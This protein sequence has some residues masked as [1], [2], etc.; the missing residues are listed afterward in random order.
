MAAVGAIPPVPPD[1]A[2]GSAARAERALWIFVGLTVFAALGAT[3]RGMQPTY[4]LVLAVVPLVLVA[5]QRTLLSWHTLLASILVVILFIP[6]RRYTVAGGAP[7]ELEPYRI[8]IALVLGSWFLALA[9]DPNVRWR[10][11]GYGAP[12][13]LLWVGI[14]GGLVA[15][16]GRVNNNS[17]QVLKSIT[18]F[19]SY[20]LV[21]CFVVSTIRKGRELDRIMKLLVGGGAIV[22]CCALY[23]WRT[24]VNLFN[25]LGRVLPFLVYQD[26]GEAMI[27]GTGARAL[28][29]AQHPIALGAG[30]VMLMPMA[31][32]LFNRTR[33]LIWLACGVLLVLGAL[34]TGSRTAA[35]MLAVVFATFAWQKRQEMM[36]LLP[37]WLVMLVVIQGVMPG[38]LQSFKF[39]L[40]PA[41]AIQEQS[42]SEGTG[43]GRVADLGP[44]LS[45][46]AHGN[47][48]V[49]EGF[50]TRVTTQDGVE[51]GAQILDDQ[52][53]TT[54]LEAGAAG[55]IALM[56]LFLRAIRRLSRRARETTGA[57]S[58]L[59][60]SLASALI[61]WTIGLFTFDAFAFIQVTFFAFI[62]LGFAS[63]ALRN[64]DD[65]DAF[66]AR[67]SG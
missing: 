36:R 26:I 6:I 32:Y 55:V 5:F 12:I 63:V 4:V 19:A 29:S 22:A 40:N 41:Y 58:W 14:L 3:E 25:G 9:A 24:G 34:A 8:L 42:K 16:P 20:F 47:P 65:T 48:F 7:I 17:E 23:E 37:I 67:H 45:E 60:T 56:W 18:F 46:W 51:G 38:T 15:N 53:L 28:A 66:P 43:S 50:G 11:T 59:A 31:F 30:L 13:A 52:W 54:L 33:K 39:I 57:E 10:A 1:V 44:S 21:L 2:P 64:D 49:G 62:I 27:R 35:I 61:A